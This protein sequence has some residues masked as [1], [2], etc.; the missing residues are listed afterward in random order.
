MEHAEDALY[1]ETLSEPPTESTQT[2]LSVV[3]QQTQSFFLQK[4]P[5]E[6]RKII[7]SFLWRNTTQGYH[8]YMENGHL[9]HARCVMD[10]RDEDPDFIQTSMD[11]VR[12]S[13][14]YGATDEAEMRMWYRRLVSPWGTRH[15]RCEERILYGR[16]SFCDKTYFA[17]LMT[18]CKRM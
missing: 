10:D 2:I 17:D 4:V 13:L 16:N 12:Q 7:Y 18:V 1:E 3:D 8:I 6:I 5:I 11:L 9:H 15:W 14:T